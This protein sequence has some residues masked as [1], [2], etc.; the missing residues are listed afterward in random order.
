L[1]QIYTNSN[2][3]VSK[4]GIIINSIAISCEINPKLNGENEL[5]ME[6]SLDKDGIYKY[7]QFNNY[8]AVSTPDFDELQLYRIYD[9]KK[10]M[11]GDSIVAFARHI[12][13]DLAKSIIFNK[14]VQGNGQQVLTKLLEDTP[15]TGYSNITDITDIRQYKLRSVMNVLA[16]SEDD[17]FINI[18]G[19]E[20]SCNNYDLT[21]NTT[22]GS[23]KGIRVTFGYNLEDIEEDLNFD[24]VITRLY[25]YAGDIVLS[26]Y[27]PYV[28]SPLIKN[29]G[30]LEDKI[31]FS[32][33][34]VK[35]SSSSSDSTTSSSSDSTVTFDTREEAESE[36]IKRCNKLY[37]KGL[38]KITANYVVKMQDLSK[39]IEYK[40]L[41]YDVLENVCLGDTVHCYNK[42]ID[43]EV[44]ARCI[45]YKWDCI[46][47]EYVEIELGDF[48]SSY[49]NMQNDRLDN[50][51]RKIVLT[52]Q[53][54]LLEVDSLDN[55]L[56]SKIEMTAQQI[57]A[58]V[59]DTKNELQ[60]QITQTANSIT[61]TVTD[62]KNE[63]QSQI[64]QTANSITSTVTDT[65][66]QLESEI[67][68]TATS[69]ISTVNDKTNS[70]Q[71]QITQ[72]SDEI[73][74]KVSKGT[75]FAS[76]IKQQADAVTI[77]IKN[78][79]DMN[80]IFNSDGQTIE[81]G[82]L[83]IKDS[84][85]NVVMQFK[86]GTAV[87]NDIEITDHSKGNWL[88][89]SLANMEEIRIDKLTT[90]TLYLEGKD[91]YDYIV[92]VLKDKGL[93]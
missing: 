42:N 30:V 36:M 10:T 18:W 13:F 56:S 26:T 43:I 41:G 27:T 32:D 16:G 55:T 57:Q 70:L 58:T 92:G 24:D 63:L 54:I 22:R 81:N 21:I 85:G 65:K 9:T 79:T 17:S 61:S 53:K 4:N 14:N 23:D 89:Q 1:I 49:I 8:I 20:I 44:E 74:L 75:D 2:P 84:N 78:Q 25:P 38:D 59:T 80:V 73:D 31:E 5:E 15:F 47:E 76:E 60:S 40:K 50:L 29:I 67:Q 12:E 46:N 62:T 35:D 28:D 34:K 66:N 72:Q 48:I 33:I 83:I 6:C 90:G 45:S 77:A 68:Q 91:M 69:I 37:D 52:E 88:Y 71:S 3:D 39:T 93:V 7:V 86:N 51:Y 82:A 19:G 87:V 64:T 11:S